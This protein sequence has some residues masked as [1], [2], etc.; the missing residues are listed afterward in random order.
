MQH[1][2]TTTTTIVVDCRSQRRCALMLG[3]S[4]L[5]NDAH[6]LGSEDSHLNLALSVPARPAS[7]SRDELGAGG[8]AGIGRRER[9]HCFSE[10]RRRAAKARWGAS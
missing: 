6:W 1:E 9:P 2:S 3:Q 10:S 4:Q 5:W 8:G 7:R